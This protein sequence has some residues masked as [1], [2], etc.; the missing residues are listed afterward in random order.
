MNQ[1]PQRKP[2]MGPPS[3]ANYYRHYP[4]YDYRHYPGYRWPYYD[5]DYYWDHNWDYDW[6]DYYR[7]EVI[8]DSTG[9]LSAYKQGLAEGRLEAQNLAQK[10][11]STPPGDAAAS[12]YTGS[13]GA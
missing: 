13:S 7:D 8:A 1:K 9:V 3:P 6:G 10:E 2:P 4:R 11:I 5:N 12:G